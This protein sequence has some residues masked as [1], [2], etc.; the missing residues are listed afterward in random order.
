MAYGG[1]QARGLIGAVAKS[2]RHSHSNAGSLTHR[3]RP[4]IEPETSWFLV[5]SFPLQHDGNSLIAVLI[6]I[7]LGTN[8]HVLTVSN[9]GEMLIQISYAF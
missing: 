6:F 4:G 1:S 9:F 5:R 2:L 3:G 8:V 7:S